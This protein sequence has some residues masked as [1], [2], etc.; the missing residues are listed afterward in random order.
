MFWVLLTVAC[1]GDE[2]PTP[3]P[4]PT[5]RL[6]LVNLPADEAPHTFA[7]EWWYFNAHLQTDDQERY[8]LHYVV[9][10]VVAGPLGLMLHVGQAAVADPQ[11]G[12]YITGEHI[13]S[14][15]GIS[16]SESPG[17]R[18]RLGEW[19]MEGADGEYRLRA[20]LRGTSFD[21]ELQDTGQVLFHGED[22]LVDFGAA[23]MSY[24]YSRPRLTV[25]GTLDLD[26]VSKEVTGLAWLDKQWGDFEPLPVAWDWASVQLDSGLDLMLT[27]VVDSE[28]GLVEAYG[29][30]GRDDGTFVHL[31]EGEF[32][33]LP[34]RGETWESPQTGAAYPTEWEVTVPEYGID[35]VLKPLLQDS[36]YV[37]NALGVVYWEAGVS[38]SGTQAGAAVS[39][40]GF[41]ELTGRTKRSE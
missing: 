2:A 15:Q 8:A 26:G 14:P 5:A 36:E 6:L 4:T 25:A 41:V 37:S 18:L 33:F 32:T 34:V 7:T 16:G 20:N 30:L 31:N 21:L 35:V 38:V 11:S 40:Q 12:R 24:Y 39:G 3:T 1:V 10:Q 22:G 23:G 19:L 29:T 9:F 27:R 28:G 13:G 17:F